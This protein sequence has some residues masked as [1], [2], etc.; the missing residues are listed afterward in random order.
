MTLTRFSPDTYSPQGEP[1]GR[2]ASVYSA[3]FGVNAR[4]QDEKKGLSAR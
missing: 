3:D 2:V 4:Q 1:C